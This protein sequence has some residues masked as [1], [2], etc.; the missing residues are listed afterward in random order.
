MPFLPVFLFSFVIF[1]A[2]VGRTGT[3]M[4]LDTLLGQLEDKAES[5]VCS[6]VIDMRMRRTEMVQSLVSGFDFQ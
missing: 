1:S 5:D 4:A 3:Y 6:L 2:G